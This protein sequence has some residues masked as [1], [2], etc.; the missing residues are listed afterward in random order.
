MPV[1]AVIRECFNRVPY[2]VAEVEDGAN[3]PLAL[4]LRGDG[5]F[6]GAADLYYGRQFILGRNSPKD[7]WKWAL[8]NLPI[9]GYPF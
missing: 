1:L 3:S 6:D 8:R 5:C 2:G 4:V 9:D 7:W